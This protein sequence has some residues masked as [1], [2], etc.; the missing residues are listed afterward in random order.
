MI[1][2]VLKT[3]RGEIPSREFES[4]P[5]RFFI[6][7]ERFI[8]LERRGRAGERKRE[9]K[10]EQAL[11]ERGGI[12]MNRRRLRIGRE[13]NFSRYIIRLNIIIMGFLFVLFLL[14]KTGSADFHRGL[15]KIFSSHSSSSPPVRSARIGKGEKQ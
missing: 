14:H 7:A 3:G 9:K 5:L 8:V 1:A 12:F 11:S 6:V 4:H 2:P 15:Q 10:R 13:V